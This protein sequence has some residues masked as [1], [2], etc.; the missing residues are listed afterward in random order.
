MGAVVPRPKESVGAAAVVVCDPYGGALRPN[1][2]PV[3]G[4]VVAGATAPS[5]GVTV[6]DAVGVP[7]LNAGGAA[8]TAGWAGVA[9]GCCAVG[10][11]NENPVLA[12]GVAEAPNVNPV[13]AAV[14]WGVPN[15]NDI[16]QIDLLTLR[17]ND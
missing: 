14:V 13:L 3:L 11:P 1:V 5:V 12:A 6:E 2:N 17:W 4:V 7:K 10:A 8:A 15:E 9:V 16:F